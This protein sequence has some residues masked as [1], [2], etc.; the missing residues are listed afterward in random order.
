MRKSSA[1]LNGTRSSVFCLLDYLPFTSTFTFTFK[2]GDTGR[3]ITRRLLRH[4]TSELRKQSGKC[5]AVPVLP[6]ASILNLARHP[7][8]QTA[9]TAQTAIHLSMDSHTQIDQLIRNFFSFISSK[10]MSC[11]VYTAVHISNCLSCNMQAC[12]NRG[13]GFPTPKMLHSIP[14]IKNSS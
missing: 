12:L 4:Q 13:H 1:Q 3:P 8:F 11:Q 5:L 14:S 2:R 10:S 7:R 6:Q 9:Q